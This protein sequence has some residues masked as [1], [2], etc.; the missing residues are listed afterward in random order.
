MVKLF[1]Y[2]NIEFI[3]RISDKFEIQDGYIIIKEYDC[4]NDILEISDNLL[5]NNKLLY[6]KIVDIN[7]K[8]E[9]LIKR[10]AQI[11]E[12]KSKITKTIWVNKKFGGVCNAYILY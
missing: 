7:V 2:N 10:I 5:D 6:G 4:E 12:Y 3:K 11:D 1:I 9:D 8:F